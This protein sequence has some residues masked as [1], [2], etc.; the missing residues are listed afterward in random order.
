M[1]R[2]DRVVMAGL[3]ALGVTYF[4]ILPL[5]GLR[6]PLTDWIVGNDAL[7]DS[8]SGTADRRR[9]SD[10]LAP[11]TG[12]V[13]SPNPQSLQLVLDRLRPGAESSLGAMLHAAHVFGA[14]CC[15][16]EKGSGEPIR[17]VD[18]LL[19][20]ERGS[21]HFGGARALCPTRY[22][23]RFP[24]HQKAALGTEQPSAESHPGQTL[25][26]L[27]G[28]GVP[29]SQ[30]IQL[31]DDETGTLQQV[32]D[33]MAAN[34]VLE[35]EIYWDAAALT[36]YVPPARSW[37]N[38]FGEEFTFDM[39]AEELLN[40]D[41]AESSCSGTHGLISLTILMRVDEQT[42]ILSPRIR[43]KLRQRLADV[44]TV[45]VEGQLPDGSW[46]LDW[47]AP[48]SGRPSSR[49]QRRTETTGVL[50]TGHHLEWLL[51]LPD[52]MR[53]DDQVFA[54]AA[55]WLLAALLQQTEDREWVQRWYCPASH[56]ARA[57]KILSDTPE[58]V[59]SGGRTRVSMGLQSES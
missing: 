7:A 58:E 34:F 46:Q 23:A 50:A 14:E 8:N 2:L 21:E 53:P 12:P 30:P 36:L 29:L 26:V 40:R 4:G 27:A 44:A 24:L 15:V 39:L 9:L 54:R 5:T 3:V 45:L 57:V 33:D 35:G 37:T 16:S 20:S 49:N 25:S 41:L 18:L 48:L 43:K 32:L 38:K 1:K 31:P 42:E 52:E 59:A 51:M 47:H 6:L 10:V 17:V 28:L 22:G 11:T 13:L 56:A 19:H 55:E